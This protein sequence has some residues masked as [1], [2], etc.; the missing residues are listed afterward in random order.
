MEALT[1]CW[2]TRIHLPDRHRHRADDGSTTATCRYCHRNIVSWDKSA[3]ALADGFNVSRLADASGRYL[4]LFDTAGDFVV[5]RYTVA[6][7][8]DEEAIEAFK[9]NLRAEYGMDDADST[10]EL[11]DSAAP[12]RRKAPRKVSRS[13]PDSLRTA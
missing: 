13:E 1:Q 11:R 3:W 2:F 8:N 9:A 12:A 5:H 4:T 7:L 6:H 10:L